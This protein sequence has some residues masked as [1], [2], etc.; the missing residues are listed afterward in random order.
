MSTT[1]SVVAIWLLTVSPGSHAAEK[2]KPECTEKTRGKLWPEKTS[3]GAD[4]PITLD[5]LYVKTAVVADKAAQ[6]GLVEMPEIR[7]K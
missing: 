7:M 5:M 4:V 3:R 2:P 6:G 1:A